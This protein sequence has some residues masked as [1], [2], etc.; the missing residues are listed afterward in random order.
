[1]D[2][3]YGRCIKTG[4]FGKTTALTL[5]DSDGNPTLTITVPIASHRRIEK[6]VV[7]RSTE[8]KGNRALWEFNR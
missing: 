5:T 7:D 3:Y 2:V 8:G 4:L 1:M 6:T